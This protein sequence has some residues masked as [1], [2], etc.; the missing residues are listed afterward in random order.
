MRTVDFTGTV[1]EATMLARDL[2]PSFM[3]ILA[4]YNKRAY[5]EINDSLRE[6]ARMDDW[7]DVSDDGERWDSQ[8]ASYI[9]NDEIWSAMNDIAPTGYYFG[10]HPG[11]GADY[12]YWRVES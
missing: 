5:D 7:R 3:D 9:L 4:L 1:S 2:I 8:A 10:A 6:Y 12:G 11:D